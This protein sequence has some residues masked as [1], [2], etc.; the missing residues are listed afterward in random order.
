MTGVQWKYQLCAQNQLCTTCGFECCSDTIRFF[1]FTWSDTWEFLALGTGSRVTAR[2]RLWLTSDWGTVRCF[3]HLLLQGS[4]M[5]WDNRDDWW[6]LQNETRGRRILCWVWVGK[7][8]ISRNCLD[9]SWS[10][11][12]CCEAGLPQANSD[13]K[14]WAQVTDNCWVHIKLHIYLFLKRYFLKHHCEILAII[15]MNSEQIYE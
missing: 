7:T 15:S 11:F 14:R 2:R 3:S 4:R 12:Q 13:R 1:R 8:C 9:N 10:A 6:E 5:M